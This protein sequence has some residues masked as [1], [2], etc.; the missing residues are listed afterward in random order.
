MWQFED[1]PA[2]HLVESAHYV[3]LYKSKLYFFNFHISYFFGEHDPNVP[4]FD[5][6][7]GQNWFT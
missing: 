3:G 2:V 6:T 7:L 1:A 5:N 4:R